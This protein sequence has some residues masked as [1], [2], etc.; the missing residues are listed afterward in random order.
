[1]YNNFYIRMLIRTLKEHDAYRE[2]T[3]EIIN[4]VF[5]K[6][7]T[8][9][10][11]PHLLLKRIY[12]EYYADNFYIN[13]IINHYVNDIKFILKKI[14]INFPPCDNLLI[15]KIYDCDLSRLIK[16]LYGEIKHEQFIELKNYV[17]YGKE[18]C[19]F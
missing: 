10:P 18:L 3:K 12:P 1:M 4:D 11:Y 19:K 17:F 13:L 8:L 9:L 7:K 2:R 6:E 14:G 15:K 16:D 5:L